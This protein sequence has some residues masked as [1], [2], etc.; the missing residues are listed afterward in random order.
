MHPGKAGHG[1]A[2]SL[3]GAA[4]VAFYVLLPLD[5][6]F[7][8]LALLGH[9]LNPAVVGSI[10]A[11]CILGV[12]SRGRVIAEA[13]QPYV[14]V[15]LLF[16][17]VLITASLRA[18]APLAALQAS[19]V[20]FCTFVLNYVV[21][22]DILRR[23]GPR[24][25]EGLVA[26]VGMGA[27]LIGIAQGVFGMHFGSYDAWY[28]AATQREARDAAGVAARTSGTMGNPILYGMAMVL[29]L[30]YV[31]GLN[32]RWKRGVAIAILALAAGLTGSRTVLLVLAVF[33][34]GGILVYRRRVL[35]LMPLLAV[36]VG[37]GAWSFGGWGAMMHDPRMRF[38]LGRVGIV[39]N[40][41]TF[42]AEGNVEI[43]KEALAV[44]WRI[45]TNQW[46]P[47]T[48]VAGEGQ[49][50]AASIGQQLSPEYGTVDNAYFTVFYEKGLVGLILLL[51]AFAVL[52]YS[53]R[54]AAQVSLH[55]YAAIGLM[56]S[57]VSFDFE[58]YSTFN[59]LAVGSMAIA[60]TVAEARTRPPILTGG[61]RMRST[62]GRSAPR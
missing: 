25:F 10:V 17:V 39:Q 50:A 34:I 29:A 45:V 7:P 12:R 52:L 53:S 38:L 59:I 5:V 33:A 28:L 40:Q 57:G 16:V 1:W 62:D 49:F 48:W 60:T 26:S 32:S 13:G 23:D 43:R 4:L 24:R 36:V 42:L 19:L 46:D 56:A 51:A 55:W 37:V 3:L 15:Q 2:A 35:W 11:F 58:A 14:V 6:G 30:P 22:L 31:L 18:D 44:G 21:F 8:R 27:A 41:V 9:A 54:T 20:Y 61:G 47:L